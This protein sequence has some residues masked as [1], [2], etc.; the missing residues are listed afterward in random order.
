MNT[1][2]VS[3]EQNTNEGQIKEQNRKNKFIIKE[4]KTAMPLG[5]VIK[6]YTFDINMVVDFE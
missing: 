5:K 2:A 6:A 4:I 1:N 3:T